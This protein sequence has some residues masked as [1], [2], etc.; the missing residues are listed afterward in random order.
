MQNLLRLATGKVLLE[1][2]PRS[3]Q[4]SVWHGC[5][6]IR[7]RHLEVLAEDEVLKLRTPEGGMCLFSWRHGQIAIL[8][9]RSNVGNKAKSQLHLA[10]ARLALSQVR[11]TGSG[12]R[13][14]GPGGGV[15]QR[16]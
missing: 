7:D 5:A 1:L 11:S 13:V 3:E 10:A 8:G 4:G 9:L 14:G 12:L 6:Y 16:F 2:D 15:Q